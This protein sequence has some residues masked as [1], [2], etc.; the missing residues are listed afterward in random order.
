MSMP[1]PAISHAISAPR[2]PVS[3]ANRRGSEKT[4]APT[5]D[6][7]TMAVIVIRVSFCTEDCCCAVSVLDICLPS[8]GPSALGHRDGGSAGHAAAVV[9]D[10]DRVAGLAGSDGDQ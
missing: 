5:M 9:S 6:P 3:W 2:M 7:T 10:L 1:A 8:S 4:P